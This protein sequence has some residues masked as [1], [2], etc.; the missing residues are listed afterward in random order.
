MVLADGVIDAREL[1]TLYKI[2]VEQ[3]GLTQ[4]AITSIVRNAGTSFVMPATLPDKIR[5]LY[6]MAQIAYAD[7]EIDS[8][9]ED[10]L[11]KYIAKM[12]FEDEN[13]NGIAEFMFNSVKENISVND[14]INQID[15]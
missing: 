2:G 7:G 11:K 13:I 9:E 1:E 8:T 5:F 15:K 4:E 10:L 14:I 3:Y 12:G 6:N